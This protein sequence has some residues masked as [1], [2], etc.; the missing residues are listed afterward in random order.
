M[1]MPREGH[2]TNP[3]PMRMRTAGTKPLIHKILKRKACRVDAK[4][5]DP[6]P[7]MNSLGSPAALRT[8]SSITQGPSQG[9]RTQRE[10]PSR[11][12]SSRK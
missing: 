8:V 11:S 9:F 6:D 10:I 12:S 7:I 1:I 4:K 2:W 3:R 5:T